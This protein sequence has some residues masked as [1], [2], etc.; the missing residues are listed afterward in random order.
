MSSVYAVRAQCRQMGYSLAL[1]LSLSVCHVYTASQ[2]S[3]RSFLPC[4]CKQHCERIYHQDKP[5]G[6]GRATPQPQ[7]GCTFVLRFFLFWDI[8]IV[9]HL[10]PQ[11]GR[12]IPFWLQL[13]WREVVAV[14]KQIQCSD[15][16]PEVSILTANQRRLSAKCVFQALSAAIN[17]SSAV[18]VPA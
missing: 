1:L 14:F 2:V 9:T 5:G 8:C 4:S 13:S 3:S 15:F 10:W 11:R 17:L 6:L 7:V 18:C 16:S 12:L